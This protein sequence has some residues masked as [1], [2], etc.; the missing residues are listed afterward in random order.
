MQNLLEA[1]LVFCN[2]CDKA[3]HNSAIAYHHENPCYAARMGW[4]C[5]EFESEELFCTCKVGA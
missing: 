3:T 4:D 2:S 5:M 1:K